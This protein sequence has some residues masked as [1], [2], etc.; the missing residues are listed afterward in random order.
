VPER[1]ELGPLDAVDPRTAPRRL[2]LLDPSLARRAQWVAGALAGALLVWGVALAQGWV[3]VA[4]AAVVTGPLPSGAEHLLWIVPAG[5]ALL[6]LAM[7]VRGVRVTLDA[8]RVAIFGLWPLTAYRTFDLTGLQGA[9][10]GLSQ[11]KAGERAF[12]VALSFA[13]A[14]VVLH[15]RDRRVWESL[16][17][18]F[19][20]RSR[21]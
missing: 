5:F 1:L 8:D 15:L 2:D 16:R 10:F 11:T 19:R 17:I 13:D 6:C 21:R 12:R 14:D 9:A 4:G 3:W 20:D 7:A 18:R